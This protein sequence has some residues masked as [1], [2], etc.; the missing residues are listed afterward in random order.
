MGFRDWRKRHAMQDPVR[1]EFHPTG[2]YYPHPGRV[3]MQEMLTG[4]VTAPG[5]PATPGEALNDLVHGHDGSFSDIL[6]CL[7]DRADP[8]RFMVLWDEVLEPDARAEARSRAADAAEEM[9][10]PAFPNRE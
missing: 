10:G 7:V 1:G 5:V 6:P 2:S 4:V 9:R 3:P 8:S